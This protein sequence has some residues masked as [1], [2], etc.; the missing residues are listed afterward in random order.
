MTAVRPDS[1]ILRAGTPGGET[2]IQRTSRPCSHGSAWSLGRLRPD[3][4]LAGSPER[5]LERIG[6]EDA[7]GRLWVVGKH[8]PETAARKEEI[9]AAAAFLAARLPEVKPWLD[10][11]ARP[12][13]RG[14]RG[15]G[16]AGL[17]VRAGD[18]PRPARLC[19]RGLAGRGAGRPSR[20]L[21]GRRRRCSAR[22]HGRWFLPGRIRPR[23]PRQGGRSEPAALRAR[24]PGRS[25]ARAL[26]LPNARRDPRGLLPRRL[27]PP[28]RDLVAGRDRRPHRSR[29]LRLQD[30]GLRRGHARRLSRH[31]R[32]ALPHE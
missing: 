28:E 11:R 19:V 5:C 31:G 21:P 24:L 8:D 10:L 20:P 6:A 3:L 9:A 12:H 15:R 16:L 27:P 23:P 32:P 13:R 1:I 17:A 18:T 7:Q 4:P 30:G 2:W 26:P 25:P 14:A 22:R 29:V